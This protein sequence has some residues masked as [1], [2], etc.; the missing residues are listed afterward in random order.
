MGDEDGFQLCLICH[1]MHHVMTW[2]IFIRV[3]AAFIFNVADTAWWDWFIWP[4]SSDRVDVWYPACTVYE[5]ADASPLL[6]ISSSYSHWVLMAVNNPV[7]FKLC[8]MSLLAGAGQLGLCAE[9]HTMPR[10]MCSHKFPHS[11]YWKKYS[12]RTKSIFEKDVSSKHDGINLASEQ[13]K[14]ANNTFAMSWTDIY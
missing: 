6:M 4:S 11:Q 14:Q 9:A 5:I 12:S 3:N 7:E 1:K 13:G 10:W 8:H 2:R